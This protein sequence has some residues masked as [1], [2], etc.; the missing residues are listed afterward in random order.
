MT[1]KNIRAADR[2]AIADASIVAL[3]DLFPEVFT[4]ERWQSHKPLKVGI[5][6]DLVASGVVTAR[7]VGLVLR[8]YTC[9]R[10][11]QLA[12][13]AGG[14]RYGLDGRPSGEVSPEQQA[15]AKAAI[16]RLDEQQASKFAAAITRFREGRAQRRA[17][18]DERIAARQRA[19]RIAKRALGLADLRRM[20]QERRAT[21]STQ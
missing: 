16:E 7:E 10:S 3:G 19:D 5:D 18:L 8:L 17:Q 2:K 12:L 11:Y 13:A 14:A 21:E 6:K 20:S 1:E 9:R 4:R 15:A